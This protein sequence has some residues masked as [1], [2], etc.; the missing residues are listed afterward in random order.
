[1][2]DVGNERPTDPAERGTLTVHDRVVERCAAYTA[3]LVEG[4]VT[5]RE[6]LDR[7]TGR[8]LPRVNAD[9]AGTVVAVDV[10]I[11]VVWASSLDAVCAQV[12]DTVR[13]QLGEQMG[14]DVS[15]VDVTVKRIVRPPASG[16]VR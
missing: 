12:R 7:A 6:T 3:R 10:D 4:V 11:A 8:R 1:M 2:D 14:L 15:S 13:D 16:R 9:V 5:Y